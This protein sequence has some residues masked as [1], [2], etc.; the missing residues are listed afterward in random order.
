MIKEFWGEFGAGVLPKARSTGR[1][2]IGLRSQD[3]LEPG[4]WGV[5]GGRVE[6]GENPRVAAEREFREETGYTGKIELVP[7]YVYT[8]GGF[9]YQNYIGLVDE[10]FVP[11]LNWESNDYRW[12]SP[13]E[14]KK[15]RRKHFGLRM[16]LK[17]GLRR[18]E[19]FVRGHRRRA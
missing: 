4:T 8:S 17:G 13:D 3:V 11:T 6:E 9:V 18:P 10:E 19:V 2:M 7:S 1:F 16:L 15:L 12:I 5:F 14:L